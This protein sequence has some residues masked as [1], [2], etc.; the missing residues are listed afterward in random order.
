MKTSKADLI[1]V[2]IPCYN[3]GQYLHEALQSVNQQTYQNYEIIVIN[4]GST[5]PATNTLLNGL[6]FPKTKVFTTDNRG[7][8]AARNYG[9]AKAIGD[10]IVTLDADDKF[11]NTFFEKGLKLL[12]A[13]ANIGVV[14]SYVKTF[15]TS[16][17]FIQH[18]RSGGSEKFIGAR[19]NSG[20]SVMFL[21]KCW[22]EV[23]GYD[24]TMRAGYED[25]DF[26]IRVTNKGWQVKV[27]EDYL[28][29]YR[30]HFSSMLTETQKNRIPILQY[31]YK[32]NEAIFTQHMKEA[33]IS[34]DK[35]NME[36]EQMY[37]GALKENQ[38][39][40]T[41]IDGIKSTWYF[42]LAMFVQNL[43]KMLNLL[44]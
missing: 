25:W 23:G 31:I 42:K 30:T 40:N 1:S 37:H 19:N 24:E 7:L 4:D 32:K 29:Y 39:L 20:A 12:E 26:W 36:V 6:D 2:V 18:Y 41:I 38:R 28:I 13:N 15:G 17:K 10:I 33:L 11:E 8:P 9:I 14:S 27:I 21:K 44:A 35:W 16:S 43:K 22:L 5:D 3:H 34:R